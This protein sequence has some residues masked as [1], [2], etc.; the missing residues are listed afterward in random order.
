MTKHTQHTHIGVAI[1]NT[2][3]RR[4]IIRALKDEGEKGVHEITLL[5]LAQAE[6]P[7]VRCLIAQ[8]DFR[9]N[10][11]GLACILRDRGIEPIFLT[12]SL[13]QYKQCQESGIEALS[14]PFHLV[15]LFDAIRHARARLTQP[16]LTRTVMHARSQ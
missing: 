16:I 4:A 7:A 1:A 15:E 13:D 6:H 12:P 8:L 14:M 10:P 2:E 5:L 9:Q 11:R 3:L